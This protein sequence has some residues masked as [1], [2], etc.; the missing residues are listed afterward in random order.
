MTNG[1]VDLQNLYDFDSFGG[2]V[3]S[4]GQ[5]EEIDKF[6]S[7]QGLPNQQKANNTQNTNEFIGGIPIDQTMITSPELARK[8][9]DLNDLYKTDYSAEDFLAGDAKTKLK[10]IGQIDDQEIDDFLDKFAPETTAEEL[11]KLFPKEDY[12]FEKRMSLA[13]L[14]L[15]LMQP[16]MGGQI[17]AVI[18][19]AGKELTTDLASIQAAKRKDAKERRAAV[20]NAQKEEE[21]A[22]LQ[23]ASN[24]FLQNTQ[25]ELSLATKIF[26]SDVDIAKATAKNKNEYNEQRQ[27]II[28]EVLKERYKTD[29]DDFVFETDEG[30]LVGPLMGVLQDNKIF[31][32]HPTAV[33]DDGYPVMVNYKAL[34]YLNP[35]TT[36]VTSDSSSKG[37]KITSA[38]KFIDI[39]N[40]IDNYD[41]VVDMALNVQRSLTL[42]PEFAGFTGGF[43]SWTQDKL[44]I[45][46]DFRNS[47]FNDDVRERLNSAANDG[48]LNP[49]FLPKSSQLLL[50]TDL[51]N[52]DGTGAIVKI[53]G[54]D[55][56]IFDDT[57]AAALKDAAN[58]AYEIMQNDIEKLE[59]AR[60]EGKKEINLGN[61]ITLGG[62]DA[63]N[64]FGLLQFQK[65]LP[66]NEAASTAI[67]YALARARKASGRLNKDDIERAAAT[68]NLYGESSKSVTTK[69]DFVISELKDAAKSQIGTSILLYGTGN[70]KD[71]KL[72][73]KFI[74]QR[75]RS[76]RALPALYQ[77]K[78]ELLDLGFTDGQ[79]TEILEGFV[80]FGDYSLPD[81]GSA[82]KVN[83][84]IEV[85]PG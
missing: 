55:V 48:T 10:D 27:D 53:N 29:V 18:A 33:D 34:G 72:I 3:T 30:E 50:P 23:L 61:G 22:R 60:N 82:P 36:D 6:I 65:D 59:Q 58:I 56:K 32:P 76:G 79:I 80:T 73:R 12:K 24:I 46:K 21:A 16:T 2:T 26:E 13:K 47:F 42:N 69:L 85:A 57:S 7:D 17:G 8:L 63:D 9:M 41:R 66:L 28:K 39:K 37:A 25:N 77:N 74:L 51:I 4:P 83:P 31:V 40:E 78:N 52:D 49:S 67:I 15:N 45:V 68:L 84:S 38:N 14:G 19:N 64:L 71:Q 70:D 44:Q 35:T 75:I 43:L 62:D 20:F 1:I 5:S 11:S 54:Q 81:P